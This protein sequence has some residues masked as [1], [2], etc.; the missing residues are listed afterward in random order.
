M[1]Y[2][3]SLK[4]GFR[5]Q[6]RPATEQMI[7]MG[8][9]EVDMVGNG[10]KRGLVAPCFKNESERAANLVIIGH[11]AEERIFCLAILDQGH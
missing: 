10:V 11:G 8:G 4:E 1:I 3:D 2:R 5:R 6:A 7:E 9:G